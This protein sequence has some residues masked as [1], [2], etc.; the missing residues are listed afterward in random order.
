MFL[1]VIPF[2]VLNLLDCAF[3]CCQEQYSQRPEIAPMLD[4][5]KFHLDEAVAD[6]TVM[7]YRLQ[8]TEDSILYVER[9][10][11]TIAH[12]YICAGKVAVLWFTF[13]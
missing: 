4:A 9:A 12:A 1:P 8:L 13:G 7:L 3:V 2:R 10:E 6:E 11:E 5:D